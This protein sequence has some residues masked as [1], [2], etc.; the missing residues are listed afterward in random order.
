MIRLAR[1]RHR[2][3]KNVY[4]IKDLSMFLNSTFGFVFKE[5]VFQHMDK[6]R[7]VLL[8]CEVRRALKENGV[9]FLQFC[10]L[11]SPCNSDNFISLSKNKILTPV[12]M[13]YW[14]PEKVKAVSN[15]IG[16]K[17]VS[18]EIKSDFRGKNREFLVDDYRRGHSIWVLALKG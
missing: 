3:L 15:A 2:D 17:V 4:S 14:L 6:E 18:V 16:F 1:K 9:V 10:N 7:V 5:A 13:R 8:L 12:Q 11:L